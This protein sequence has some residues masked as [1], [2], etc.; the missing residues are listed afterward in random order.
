MPRDVHG[1]K[2]RLIQRQR[3][4]GVPYREA[5]RKATESL[6]RVLKKQDGRK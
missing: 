5:E 2:E 1:A 6:R 3:K 4:E